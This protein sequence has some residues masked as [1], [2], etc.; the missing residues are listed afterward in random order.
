[1]KV[2][3]S[4]ISCISINFPNGLI[5]CCFHP[6]VPD[7]HIKVF[8]EALSELADAAEQCRLGIHFCL[9]FQSAQTIKKHQIFIRAD[10]EAK[11]LSSSAC[12][13]WMQAFLSQADV[14]AETPV[15][16]PDH[17]VLHLF[18]FWWSIFQVFNWTLFLWGWNTNRWGVFSMN[19]VWSCLQ[20]DAHECVC[21]DVASDWVSSSPIMQTEP[22][23]RSDQTLHLIS[24]TFAR[25][26][27]DI[28]TECVKGD[29]KYCFSDFPTSNL[30]SCHSTS[31]EEQTSC[32][33]FLRSSS[34][35]SS[36]MSGTAQAVLSLIMWVEK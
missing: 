34:L 4:K 22:P 29:R 13:T 27:N 33:T 10:L 36:G 7:F 20:T 11:L 21:D 8:L 5:Y 12:I 1:M 30:E 35:H 28:S 16:L 17:V 3:Q 31:E 26:Q 32:R 14:V 19:P 6:Q 25:F 2:Q 23:G 15:S 24:F 18:S 9:D